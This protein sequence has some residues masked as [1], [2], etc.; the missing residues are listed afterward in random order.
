MKDEFLERLEQR[1]RSQQQPIGDIRARVRRGRSFTA[2]VLVAEA[3][4]ALAG[5]A[6]G[7][8]FAVLALQSGDISFALAALALL[9][10]CPAF[11]ASIFAAR[12]AG[13]VFDSETPEGLLRAGLRQ[14]EASLRAIRLTRAQF[15]YLAGFAV[16][17]WI[18]QAA[19]LID[20]VSF[21]ASYT[22]AVFAVGVV[23]WLWLDWR[24]SKIER[25]RS[26]YLAALAQ[27]ED[28]VHESEVART[29]SVVADPN[30]YQ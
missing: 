16:L 8:G 7:I 25:A 29:A 14:A 19:G 10:G 4:L 27:F 22:L 2:A 28:A 1:W 12:N 13:L 23:L 18:V 26:A 24:Q 5:V 30:N 15:P 17:L 21:L 6:F 20:R 11:A 9:V 3:G